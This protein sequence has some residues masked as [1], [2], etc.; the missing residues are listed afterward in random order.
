MKK[1]CLLFLCV[2]A[3]C[4]MVSAQPDK[5]NVP[6]AV[7]IPSSIEHP[8]VRNLLENR[9]SLIVSQNGMS[10]D[11]FNPRFIIYPTISVLAEERTTTPPILTIVELQVNIFIA[12]F[13]DNKK[14]AST[15]FTVKGGGQS[16][17][18]AFLDAVK[19]IKNNSDIE[20]CL[21]SGKQKIV[22]YYDQICDKVILQ[23]NEMIKQDQFYESVIL[24]NSIPMASDCFENAQTAITQSYYRFAQQNCERNLRE[25]EKYYAMHDIRKSLEIIAL[26]GNE[27]DCR[28]DANNLYNNILGYIQTREAEAKAEKDQA[29]ALALERELRDYNLILKSMDYAYQGAQ[30][31]REN[32]RYQAENDYY[33]QVLQELFIEVAKMKNSS[34]G[35]SYDSRREQCI[36]IIK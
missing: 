2:W 11:Q 18:R 32:Q 31:E 6:I 36:T 22:E 29:K 15:S 13:V 19:K 34:Q 24:L 28:Q 35:S 1:I 25:A 26:I 9:L 10:D 21:A 5:S 4:A 16:E 8:T 12:D 33:K 20:R 7:Y 27:C 3:S 30:L 14:F 23:A 17:E